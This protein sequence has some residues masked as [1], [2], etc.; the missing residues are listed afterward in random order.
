M[1]F[2]QRLLGSMRPQW[3]HF[4]IDY[5]GLKKAIK[6]STGPES[7]ELELSSTN[8]LQDADDEDLELDAA[9]QSDTQDSLFVMVFSG[10]LDKVQH[11]RA[12]LRCPRRC[13]R[14]AP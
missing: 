6:A 7:D 3:S 12:A 11:S 13:L 5:K 9:R 2:G 4:Y 8:L 14:A 1:K 10:Q